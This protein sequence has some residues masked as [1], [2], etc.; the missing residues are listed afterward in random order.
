MV[1]AFDVTFSDIQFEADHFVIDNIISD[2]GLSYGISTWYD[3][4]LTFNEDVDVTISNLK[5]GSKY[6]EDDLDVN[7]GRYTAS[8]HQPQACAFRVHDNAQYPVAVIFEGDESMLTMQ[9]VFG[10]NGCDEQLDGVHVPYTHVGEV[11]NRQC[12]VEGHY[13]SAANMNGEEML[14]LEG[15]AEEAFI[16]QIGYLGNVLIVFIIS[17]LVVGVAA[18]YYCCLK[19]DKRNAREPDRYTRVTPVDVGTM[20]YGTL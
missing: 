6:L 15:L 16:E 10:M 7:M 3:S 5:A 8:N 2:T 9:C 19:D 20:G 12:E 14:D 18:V 13:L 1:H 11:N 17:V 4:T